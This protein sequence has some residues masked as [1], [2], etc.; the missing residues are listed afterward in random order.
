MYRCGKQRP[1]GRLRRVPRQTVNQLLTGLLLGAEQ[2]EDWTH[3][4]SSGKEENLETLAMRYG[5]FTRAARF[6]NDSKCLIPWSENSRDR[7]CEFN[8]LS[9]FYFLNVTY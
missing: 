2:H 5:S 1:I 4:Q 9:Y 8:I 6:D 7:S 3:F